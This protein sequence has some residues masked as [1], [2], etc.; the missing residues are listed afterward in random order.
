MKT[1][2]VI[3]DKASEIARAV[4]AAKALGWEVLTCDASFREEE[5]YSNNTEWIRMIPKV[6]GV[7]T[8]LMWN[9][10]NHGEK[11]MGL[12]VVIEAL[13]K[14]KP[15]VVCT[16]AREFDRGHHGE[17]MGFIND[18]Y[19][20]SSDR[21]AFGLVETKDWNYAMKKLSERFQ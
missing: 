18:G 15:V 5:G 6:D 20:T 21:K 3:D 2:L 14:G 1:V 11:T 19:Y 13:S 12:L 8:D 7:V 9:H 4:E 17:A 16:N 10:D